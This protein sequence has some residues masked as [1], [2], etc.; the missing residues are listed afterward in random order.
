MNRHWSARQL[1]CLGI[2]LVPTQAQSTAEGAI[3]AQVF[4][5]CMG[6]EDVA[7]GARK[8]MG[9]VGGG[10]LEPSNRAI[11]AV[12]QG[13]GLAM[14]ELVEPGQIGHA[15]DAHLA[16]LVAMSLAALQVAA[17][18][19]PR[20]ASALDEHDIVFFRH[21]KEKRI[22]TCYNKIFANPAE[23]VPQTIEISRT[24][25]RPIHIFYRL[26]TNLGR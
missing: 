3:E 12:D 14:A 6:R 18:R 22:A 16:R 24:V 9:N 2:N 10:I 1:R 21:C 11:E 15:L 5:G 19:I 20:C 13:I 4:S 8:F 26:L 23:C 7:T 25:P 17:R